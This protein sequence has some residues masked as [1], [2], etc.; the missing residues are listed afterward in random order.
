V[1]YALGFATHLGLA[2]H[3]PAA[4]GDY[5]K[6]LKVREGFLRAREREIEISLQ[7]GLEVLEVNY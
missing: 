1:G 6:R 4:I 7:Q 5:W 2:G 3:F